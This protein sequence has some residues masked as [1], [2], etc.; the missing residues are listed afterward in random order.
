MLFDGKLG[1]DVEYARNWSVAVLKSDGMSEK[2]CDAYLSTREKAKL[3]SIKNENR[4][5]QWLAGR[6]AAKYLFLDQLD[7]PFN[8]RIEPRQPTLLNLTSEDLT[9]LSPWMYRKIEVLPKAPRQSGYPRRARMMPPP[10]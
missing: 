9:S 7:V 5:R 2:D 10:C 1:P 4:S 8:T 3:A 6:L